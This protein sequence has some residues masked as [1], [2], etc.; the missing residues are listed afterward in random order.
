MAIF[1]LTTAMVYRKNRAHPNKTLYQVKLYRR[2][3]KVISG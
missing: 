2:T 3:T 1:G